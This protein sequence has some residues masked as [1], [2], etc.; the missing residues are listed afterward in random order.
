MAW[1]SFRLV[2][3]NRER[4]MCGQGARSLRWC[5]IFRVWEHLEPCVQI[6]NCN[7][8]CGETEDHL[9]LVCAL[10]IAATVMW[11][12]KMQDPRQA[13]MTWARSKV[14]GRIVWARSRVDVEPFLRRSPD[15]PG[16]TSL[17]IHTDGR[18]G[19][20][21]PG[22]FTNFRLTLSRVYVYGVW[23]WPQSV[24]QNCFV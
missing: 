11:G 12:C 5:I 24:A 18:P 20:V 15:L 16:G 14:W 4:L 7:S 17:A 19:E 23:L 22:P 1:H 10:T 2:T 9:T 8:W 3:R 21:P 6:L 13:K